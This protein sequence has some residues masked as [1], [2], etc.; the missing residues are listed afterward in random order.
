MLTVSVE[1][2]FEEERAFREAKRKEKEE[3]HLYLHVKVASDPQFRAHQGFD[4]AV[5]DEKNPHREAAPVNYKMLKT[6]TIEDLTRQVAENL[7]AEPENL[8]LWVMVNRQNR[9]VRPDQPLM[10]KTMSKIPYR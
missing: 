5:L 10:E 9:T 4:L 6:A 3:Q 2:R 1:A 7:G 8:R